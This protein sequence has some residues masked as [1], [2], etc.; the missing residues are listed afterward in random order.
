MQPRGVSAFTR[1]ARSL[2]S[3]SL[4]RPLA[5]AALALVG[6]ATLAHAQATGK[7]EGRV[8]DQAGAPIANAQVFIVGTAFNATTNP[9]GYYFLNNVPAG[10]VVMRAAFVGYRPVQVEGLR[11][12]AGQ[13]ITQDFALEKTVV[14]LEEVQV[15]TTTQ[16]LVPRDEVAT[17][18]RIDG[19]MAAKLPVDRINQVL[20]LQPGVVANTGRS[21][22]SIR[23]GRSDENAT[24]VD[25]VPVAPG[26]RNSGASAN[27][28]NPGTTGTGVVGPGNRID[29][30]TTGLEEASVTTGASSAEFGNAQSG[31]INIATRTGSATGYNAHLGF[32]SDEPFGKN[33][34][35]GYNRIE[36]SFGGPLPI[37]KG[38]TFYVGGDLEGNKANGNPTAGSGLLGLG[39]KGAET[40]P[41]F[42]LAGVDTTVSFTDTSGVTTTAPIQAYA[43][44]RG[45]CSQFSQSV[46][47]GIASN[48]G[49]SC[50]GVRAP[51]SSSSSYRVNGKL[52]FSY[53]TGSKL[54]LSVLGNQTQNRVLDYGN[55]FDLGNQF[56]NRGWSRAII[57]NWTQNLSKSAERAL[58]LD[59]YFSYQ[60]DR[61]IQSP[62]GPG[63]GP[64][65][66]TLGFYA[67]PYKFLYDFDNFPL[68]TTLVN[69]FRFFTGVRSPTGFDEGLQS[70]DLVLN[71]PYGERTNDYNT[72]SSASAFVTA[73]FADAGGPNATRLFLQRENRTIGKSTLDWQADRY[74]RIRLGGEFTKYHIENLQTSLVTEIFGDAYIENPLRWAGFLEDRLD[75]G[76]L[77]LVGGV[78]YDWYDSRASH[79]VFVCDAAQDAADGTTNGFCGDALA[80]GDT[81]FTPR[82]ATNPSFNPANPTQF[83]LR[84]QSHHY[85][86][87]HVQVSF[88][89]TDRTNFRLSYA[90][91]VQAPDFSLIYTG[92]NTDLAETNTNQAYGTDIDFG[93][94]ITFEFGIRHAFSDDMVLDLAAYNKDNVA[95]PTIRLIRSYDPNRRQSGDVRYVTNLDFGNTRGIDV[96]LD[97]RFGN[98]FNGTIS[99]SFQQA[100]ST[101]SDPFTYNAFGAR[102]INAVSGANQPPPQATIPVSQSRPHT[103]GGAFSASFPSDWQQGTVLG[104]IL[105]DFGVFTTFQYASGTA[106]TR[107]EQQG[108]EQVISGTVCTRGNYVGGLNTA[109]LPAFKDLSMRFTKGFRAGGLNLSAFLD[110]RNILNLRNV[111]AVYVTTNDVTNA[112][113]QQRYFAADSAR[114]A[115]QATAA[116]VYGADGTVDL[117]FGGAGANGCGTF[118]TETGAS[119]ITAVQDCVYLVRA[120]QRWGNGDGQFT[121]AEQQRAFKAVYDVFRGENNFLGAG[122]RLRLG[123]ELDF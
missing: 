75:L 36:A 57:A 22:L 25:G 114:L 32:E 7:I 113:E 6:G 37:L 41:I 92:I 26:A 3:R 64:G 9:Q 68:D 29:I 82:I 17:K 38:L 10:S 34:S 96:R 80:V 54:A 14:Q 73:G 43:I 61:Y 123:L 111:L 70:I 31:V 77:V 19:E 120:E 47:P 50:H 97:R 53:G 109:R 107:C 49:Q 103:L 85:L 74:N 28:A 46:N 122:R 4:T 72:F 69:N 62:F 20:A 78:R 13:T 94:T 88:P 35:F 76:D 1:V 101:G 81:T 83:L 79:P 55:I 33:T 8:R 63:F 60:L 102:I 112:V 104:A 118:T 86:S 106:Y 23:G 100:R 45:D 59:S 95:N 51:S 84:D 18:Q 65:T 93:K 119:A 67:K 98:I 2:V 30:S 108:N 21:Q 71:N 91:Q 24:Y 56:G 115:A 110:A 39:G 27:A 116:G 5:L 99:Y 48:Y 42:V 105:S 15:V 11:V 87:P 16:P 90:H 117:T 12:L 89:V 44:Y 58:A 52:N 40:T 66:G 121:L